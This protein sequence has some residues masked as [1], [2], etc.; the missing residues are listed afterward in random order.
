MGC[1]RL[2][3]QAKQHLH[4]APSLFPLICTADSTLPVSV[5]TNL[6]CLL[7]APAR[8]PYSIVP[9]THQP[10]VPLLHSCVQMLR[11]LRL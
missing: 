6:S 8:V 1:Q 9:H 10:G 2:F 4:S 11:P 3:I 5:Y 7:A